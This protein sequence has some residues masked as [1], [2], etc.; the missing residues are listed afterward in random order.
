MIA[1][2][3]VVRAEAVDGEPP[4]TVA[5]ATAIRSFFEGAGIE[6]VDANGGESGVQMRKS[7][8]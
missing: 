6:F 2:A 4:I 1:T 5:Q 8:R 3:T 7:A